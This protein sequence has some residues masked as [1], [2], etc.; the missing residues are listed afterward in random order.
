MK[1]VMKKEKLH[2]TK[3][4]Y[5]TEPFLDFSNPEN[6]QKVRDAISYVESNLSKEYPL[7]IG[8]KEF[9]SDKKIKSINP[10]EYSQVVGIFQDAT[11]EQAEMAVEAAEKAF[12]T[13]S[14]LDVYQRAHIFFRAANILRQRKYE[15]IAWMILEVG[16][17][18]AE[19]DA[20]VA[21]TID[22]LEYYAQQMINIHENP[23][24]LLRFP[25][26]RNYY[27][28][29]PL[30]VVV[31]IPPWNFPLAI[32][33]GMSI[34]AMIAGNTVILKPS[35]DACF[36]SYFFYSI[37]KEAGLP[38]GVLNFL[39][40]RGSVV[41]DFLVKHPKVRM[42]AF[43]GSKD[44]GINIY[45]EAANVSPGQ[46]HLKRVIAEMG[47][48]NAIIV[49]NI[50]NEE[51]LEYAAESVLISAFGY[52]G[53][54]CSACSRLLLHKNIY[55]KFMSIFLEKV[56]R[57]EIGLP[58]ENK[59]MGPVINKSA[60]EKIMEYIEIGKKQN[61]LVYGGNKLFE[62][63]GYYIE[64]TIFEN[65][66]P[67]DTIAQEEIFGPVLAV[68]EF[69]DF[70]YAIEIANSTQYGLTGAVFS[71]DRYNI[72]KA[73]N[74]FHCGNLYINRKCTGA[75]VGVHPFGGFNMSG[76]D[77][78]AGGPDYLLYFLQGR[79]VSEKLDF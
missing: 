66:K 5:Q 9:Y 21:E 41:G 75:I 49:D 17:N 71:E 25:G 1:T 57:I 28:Y 23:Q 13:W 4:D 32:A 10:A 63:K 38:D 7:F 19:A 2:Y 30:G 42:I 29:L 54:K 65:V 27:H 70:D 20:D 34:A 6:V 15:A 79:S 67:E 31:V 36:M 78:K 14:K 48:K 61:K 24:R 50:K 33:A 55:D 59:F 22:Y 69:E 8:G 16:K 37:M 43:T 53:Q 73:V 44:V 74:E 26:E 47:G 52:Q 40:G 72:Q 58:K 3:N 68:M 18:Y 76:T 45:K 64:P 51:F 60:Q 39:S 12:K 62:D 11:I 77:A 35:Y 46:K 56:K